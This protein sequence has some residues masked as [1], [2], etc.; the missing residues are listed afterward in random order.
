MSRTLSSFT[1]PDAAA[2]D[3][4]GGGDAVPAA[5]AEIA[6]VSDASGAVTRLPGVVAD[7]VRGHP[8]SALLPGAD[9]TASG[10][11]VEAT[12]FR[13]GGGH[14][15]GHPIRNADRLAAAAGS[16]AN[17]LFEVLPDPLCVCTP[18][19]RFVHANPALGA[20]LGHEAAELVG[21]PAVRF[22]H[23]D[24]RRAT[25]G[26]LAGMAPG[27]AVRGFRN[28]VRVRDGSFRWIDWDARRDGDRIYAV[29]RDVTRQTDIEQLEAANQ[30][31][32][33]RV[34]LAQPLDEI[35][36]AVCRT[37]ERL[38]P[39]CLCT[40]MLADDGQRFLHAVAAPSLPS[41]YAA[42]LVNLPIGP[43]SGSCGTA[44]HFRQ[45]VVVEDIPSDPLWALARDVVR[46]FG[47]RACWSS[48]LLDGAGRVL[49]TFSIYR[50]EPHL[51]SPWEREVAAKLTNA[52]AIAIQRQRTTDAVVAA[53]NTAEAANARLAAEIDERKRAEAALRRAH[54][55][56]EERVAERTAE[57]AR[58]E[59]RL[60]LAIEV[61]DVGTWE[62]DLE[63][64]RME[65]SPRA[66]AL[67]GFSKTDRITLET[68]EQCVHPADLERVRR[69]I[70]AAMQ[71]EPYRAEFRILRRTAA[72]PGLT[73][74]GVSSL[75]APE[76]PGS[77]PV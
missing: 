32:L 50:T 40:V 24:D 49:G 22:V 41:A 10:M 71:G 57:L 76:R 30:A 77:R 52:A 73:P 61:A 72:C 70:A 56:L 44:A 14:L 5:P 36:A 11:P 43:C 26:A 19:G 29:G 12:S 18:D 28:R 27:Q 63:T 31:V 48:P 60:R 34:L 64:G 4:L 65:G 23:A 58:T 1:S 42:G 35:L 33:D 3:R 59:E 6:L 13:V 38:V 47:L 9:A 25:A 17:R 51:P 39:G 62:H 53:R 67:F 15:T 20:A 55:E 75:E 68:F 21:R 46:P 7:P 54:D 69:C 8:V 66:A 2:E 74:V 45:V 37:V 16:D